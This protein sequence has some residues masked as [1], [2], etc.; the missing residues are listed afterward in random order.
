MQRR[1]DGWIGP[2][3]HDLRPMGWL[4]AGGGFSPAQLAG[5]V[6]WLDA[7]DAATLFQ[8]AARSTPVASDGDPV[9]GWTDKGSGTYHA[10][11]ATAAKRATNRPS[12]VNGRGAVEFDGTDDFLT[13]TRMAGRFG[14]G[15]SFVMV[16][17]I[18]EGQPVDFKRP[19]GSRVVSPRQAYFDFLLSSTGSLVQVM[20]ADHVSY[21]QT[22]VSLPAGDS[23]HGVL[24]CV[25]TPG[26]AMSCYANGSL[27]G[28]TSIAGAT[29]GN[30]A[31]A[32]SETPLIG[33]IAN[34]ASDIGHCACQFA[35]L[36]IYNRPLGSAERQQVEQYAL[37]KFGLSP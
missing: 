36:L 37:A 16:M 29:W 7:D 17:R 2:P 19:F 20:W 22:M 21:Q 33:A 10:L 18:F 13:V 12:A 8:D 26:A 3:P 30:I 11:Q 27:T 24:T 31:G 9:G 15:F 34:G 35:E 1:R 4:A 28:T 25:A 14:S 6:L 32:T 5:L 23:G